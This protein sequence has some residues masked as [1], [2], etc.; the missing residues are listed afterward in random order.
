M[1]GYNR[2]CNVGDFA[3]KVLRDVIR[4]VFASELPLFPPNPDF[5]NAGGAS[6]LRI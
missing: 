6:G 1:I 2:V 5:S 3:D 4:E